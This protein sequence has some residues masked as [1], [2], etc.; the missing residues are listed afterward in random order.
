M[1][2]KEEIKRMH[3]ANAYSVEH[4]GENIA[5]SDSF[6]LI[7]KTKTETGSY[8]SLIKILNGKASDDLLRELIH[9]RLDI[10]SL[11][12]EEGRHPTDIHSESKRDAKRYEE[13]IYYILKREI[14]CQHYWEII[15]H[16]HNLLAAAVQ[17]YWVYFFLRPS[18]EKPDAQEQPKTVQVASDN[19]QIVEKLNESKNVTY[20]YAGALADKAQSDFLNSN[21]FAL[22]AIPPGFQ[23]DE[24]LIRLYTKQNE[25]DKVVL[26]HIERDLLRVTLTDRF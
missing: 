16:C 15:S 6:Q 4:V 21:H 5:L 10:H 9:Q 19:S 25:L 17:L 13:C 26:G 24:H 22:L 18:S 14:F 1:E 2:P 12:Q 20:V 8:I 7:D 3:D 11:H 23:Q